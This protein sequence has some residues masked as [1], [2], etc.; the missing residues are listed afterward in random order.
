[1]AS[2]SSK[3]QDFVGF[4]VSSEVSSL[5]ALD[6]KLLV[7]AALLLHGGEDSDEESN[8]VVAILVSR[9]V[10]FIWNLFIMNNYENVFWFWSISLIELWKLVLERERERERK[11]KRS[12]VVKS[13]DILGLLIC[14]KG[15]QGGGA[16][17]TLTNI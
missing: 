8:G 3:G 11:I 13:T 14:L 12:V 5:L 2:R 6:R 10:G 4:S 15:E 1:M 16:T 17:A 9:F 7:L